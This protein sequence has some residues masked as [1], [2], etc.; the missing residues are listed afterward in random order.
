M[1][2]RLPLKTQA[3]LVRLSQEQEFAPRSSKT[4]EVR[5]A[6]PDHRRFANASDWARLG[7]G[8]FSRGH[9]NEME[10]E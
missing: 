1:S 2:E 4:I 10:E 9:Q 3:K 6:S 7:H 5:C 8:V